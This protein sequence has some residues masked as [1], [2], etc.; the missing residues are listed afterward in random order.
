MVGDQSQRGR[1]G[2][3]LF[4]A[5]IWIDRFLLVDLEFSNIVVRV[6]SGLGGNES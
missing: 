3:I 4:S 5:C 2:R 6:G 1:E